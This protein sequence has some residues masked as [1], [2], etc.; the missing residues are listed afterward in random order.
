[1]DKRDNPF[2]SY[3][4]LD[5]QRLRDTFFSAPKKKRKKKPHHKRILF[6]PMI[7]VVAAGII[8]FFVKYDFMVVARQNI[9]PEKNSISLLHSEI[10]SA[11]NVLGQDKRLVKMEKSFIYLTI[12][13]QEKTTLL[14]NLK[15]TIDLK[16][17]SLYLYL[18]KSEAPLKI[19]ITVRDSRFFSNSLNPLTIDVKEE[20]SSYVKIPID[21]KSINLQ[22]TNLYQINQINLYFYPQDKEKEQWI[23]I[24]D[25]VLS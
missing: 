15:K 23:L 24:K 19:G 1:V 7:A 3:A 5:S 6:L 13:P 21:L 22:N 18:K 20:N 25:L 9:E 4:Y 14:I 16:S 11:I 17:G 8:L 12:P 2:L 10:F